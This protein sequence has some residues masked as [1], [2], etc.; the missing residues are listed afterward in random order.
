MEMYKKR[1]QEKSEKM[2]RK[3]KRI[4]KGRRIFEIKSQ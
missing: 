3:R 4:M 2:K 1:I